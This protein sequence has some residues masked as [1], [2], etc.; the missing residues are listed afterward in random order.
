MIIQAG[1]GCLLTQSEDVAFKERR[2]EKN[3]FSI[4]HSGD[5][6]MEGNS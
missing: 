3:S 6:I 1:N 5:Y 4:I 2:F